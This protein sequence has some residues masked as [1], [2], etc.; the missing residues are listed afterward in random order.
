M[1]HRI[2]IAA[3]LLR[4]SAQTHPGYGDELVDCANRLMLLSA[5]VQRRAGLPAPTQISAI[6]AVSD[7]I[8]RLAEDLDA[9][10]RTTQRD[11]FPRIAAE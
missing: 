2:R 3:E 1:P 8:I 6:P 4:S 5:T 7:M 11:R 9:E 10:I